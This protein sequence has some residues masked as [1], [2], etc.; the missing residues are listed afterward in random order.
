M[1]KLHLY[2][3]NIAG[4]FGLNFNVPI[5]EDSL[6]S[7]DSSELLHYA[8]EKLLVTGNYLNDLDSA[9]NSSWDKYN[10]FNEDIKCISD[11]KTSVKESYRLFA[12]S[13]H[14]EFKEKLWIN[15][16]ISILTKGN[17]VKK[18]CHSTHQN[19][20]LTGFI[21]LTKNDSYTDFHL[22]EFEHLDDVGIIRIENLEKTIV[23]FPQWL[24][25]SVSPVQDDLRISLAFDLFTE[26]AINYY[27]ENNSGMDVPI[28]RATPL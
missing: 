13:Y 27:N 20:Y 7:F 16:W 22:P 17:F 15:G 1:S 18:H 19:S 2:E 12:K 4:D 8:H 3:M 9:E 5:W 11:F 6:P 25:H 26:D 21:V 10:I 14:I 24:F 28:K 23:M